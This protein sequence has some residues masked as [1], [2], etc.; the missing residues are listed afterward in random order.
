MVGG[1]FPEDFEGAGAKDVE[2]YALVALQAMEEGAHLLADIDE[3]V[4]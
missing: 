4:P 2:S 3:I 1:A